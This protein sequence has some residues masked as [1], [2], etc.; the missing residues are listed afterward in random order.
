M[1][2][3]Q[4]GR[5]HICV[6]NYRGIVESQHHVS[7]LHLTNVLG[8][9]KTSCQFNN[10]TNTIVAQARSMCATLA[11]DDPECTHL[12]YVDDDMV[13]S[14]EDYIHLENELIENDLDFLGA[15][16]FANCVPTKPCIFGRVPDIEEWNTEKSWWHIVTQYPRSQRFQVYATGFGMAILTRRMLEK[17]QAHHASVPGW[18]WFKFNHPMCWNEDVAFC[19]NANKAGI[20]LWVDSRVT[21][22]H[23]SKERPLI[24]EDVFDRQGNASD[25][26]LGVPP[27]R[28]EKTLAVSDAILHEELREWVSEPVLP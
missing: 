12:L 8:Q 25:Y 10:P 23:I 14:P 11:L 17:M 2:K 20:P 16:A 5:L 28:L 4:I 3:Q 13:F 18:N 9:R 22:G 26:N 21:I 19:L 24:S 27:K 1:S 7:M 15:L 6:P